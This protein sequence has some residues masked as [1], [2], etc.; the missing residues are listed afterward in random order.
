VPSI[1]QPPVNLPPF[2]IEDFDFF[3]LLLLVLVD[4]LDRETFILLDEEVAALKA[5]KAFRSLRAL[6]VE[7]YATYAAFNIF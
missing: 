6:L 5:L 1:L 2:L 7:V 3:F 4:V